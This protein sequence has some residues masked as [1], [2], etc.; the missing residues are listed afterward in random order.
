M[1]KMQGKAF[2]FEKKNY[3]YWAHPRYN[4]SRTEK[5]RNVY[6]KGNITSLYC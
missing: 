6:I 1:K 4:E 3:S 2:Y 5:Y